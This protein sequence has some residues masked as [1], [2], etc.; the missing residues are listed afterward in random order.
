MN[1]LKHIL[2]FTVI[3]LLIAGCNTKE[4][5]ES[6]LQTAEDNFKQLDSYVEAKYETSTIQ[7]TYVD[8]Q[9]TFL[10]L[11]KGEE[12]HEETGEIKEVIYTGI[13]NLV[14]L[15]IPENITNSKE[16]S[17][18]NPT[19]FI[20]RIKEKDNSKE[21]WE[22]VNSRSEYYEGSNEDYTFEG[23][24]EQI[25][26][27][28]G[29]HFKITP[30]EAH[31]KWN[32]YDQKE[33]KEELK[34]DQI[35]LFQEQFLRPEYLFIQTQ[36]VPVTPQ[37]EFLFKQDMDAIYALAEQ[38]KQNKENAENDK[39]NKKD[40][41]ESEENTED[42][43]SNNEEDIINIVGYTGG[44]FN[45][46]TFTDDI[47]ELKIDETK[48]TEQYTVLTGTVKGDKEEMFVVYENAKVEIW[49]D[50]EKELVV[51]EVYYN[52]DGKDVELQDGTVVS[53]I[54][55]FEYGYFNDT[56]LTEEFKNKKVDEKVHILKHFQSNSVPKF[57]S[58]PTKEETF[59]YIQERLEHYKGLEDG[60]SEE[61]HLTN[62][63]KDTTKYFGITL[64]KVEENWN[65]SNKTD[66]N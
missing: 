9:I 57:S 44:F 61:E 28:T 54:T 36:K 20:E 63:F 64:E 11:S 30:E 48:T 25:F 32:L 56:L 45:L 16:L 60:S 66:N 51:R 1:K 27:D 21:I 38:Q 26:N 5:P 47:K 8:T 62:A 58:E 15:G 13:N 10:E 42:S 14:K 2:L 23:Y 65:A 29:D 39:D 3:T 40:V 6:I 7:G 37:K 18:T 24:K 50:N 49:I 53:D 55:V 52:L 22:Y 31:Y 35:T 17:E 19:L 59:N 46:Q 33:N 34:E 12:V 4:T 41:D 43:T